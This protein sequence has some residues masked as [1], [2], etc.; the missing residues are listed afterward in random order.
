[1]GIHGVILKLEAKCTVKLIIENICI[2]LNRTIH[3]N[4]QIVRDKIHMTYNRK[5][6]KYEQTEISN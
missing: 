3:F 6:L 1:M 2:L 4:I 5:L